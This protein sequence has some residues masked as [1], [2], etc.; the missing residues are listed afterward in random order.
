MYNPQ[1]DTFVKVADSG[2]FT[3]AAGA[4]HI[5]PT[6]VIKQMNLLEARL[7]LKLFERTHRG[8][9]LTAAGESLRR[10]AEYII[11]YSK[12]SVKRAREAS[13]SDGA[14]IRVGT[15]PMTPAEI[16]VK[17]WPKLHELR[18]ELKFRV[19]PFENTPENAREILKNLGRD[20][21]MVAGIF[22]ETLLEYRQCDGLEL[23]R[24]PIC[25]AVSLSHPLAAKE[26]LSVT[27]LYGESFMLISRGQMKQADALRDDLARNHPRI[28]I[29]DFDFY[30]TEVFNRCENGNSLLMAV[31]SWRN[32]HPL[33]RIIPVEWNHAIPFGLL[34]AHDAS[35]QVR[36]CISAVEEIYRR[37]GRL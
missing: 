2:S 37:D 20:I 19:V 10:D 33:L 29:V 17:L 11:Q 12:E 18:P 21:D 30:N 7:G 9:V 6:A 31:E 15:S 13:R 16:L 22:D 1:L 24:A 3:K 8:L 23:F 25:C 14:V 28:R 35:P 26:R 32:V 4:L 5:S 34:H 36:D 27:D